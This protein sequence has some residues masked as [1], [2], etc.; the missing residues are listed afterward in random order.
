MNEIKLEK[1]LDSKFN[2]FKEVND[3]IWEYAEP[4]FQETCS[5]NLQKEILR[6]EG[7]T[8]TE[9]LGGIKTAFSAS[10]G[11]G[12]PVIGILGEFD[13]LP[14]LSQQ[15]DVTEKE[16]TD[17][18]GWGHGCGH[19]TLGT[20]CMEACVALKDYLEEEKLE[21]TIIYFGCPGEEGGAGKAFMVREGCFQTCDICLAWHPYSINFGSTSTLANARVIYDFHGISSHA[22]TSPHLGRSALDAVEL[23]NVGSNY[24]REHIL[25]EARIHYAITNSGGDA[26]NVVQADAQVIYAIRA[27][28]N[29]Q[30]IELLE[31]V[32]AVA[33]GA[34]MMTGTTVDIHVASAYADVLQNK[35]L[36]TLVYEKMKKVLPVEYSSEELEYAAKFHKVGDIEDIKTYES[37]AV[38]IL[39]DSAKNMFEGPVVKEVL[40]PSNLKMGSTD[41]GDVSWNIP[42]SWFGVACYSLGTPAH[43]WQA[44]AQGKSPLAHK[45]MRAAATILSMTAL[46]LI[47][48]PTLVEK[49]KKD[50]EIAKEGGSYK[51]I[52][53]SEIK[54]GSF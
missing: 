24:L 37:M 46:E 43:S 39:G 2:I 44:V 35:T 28:G 50:L 22:A 45:G 15:A 29:N 1:I 34:A 31:R 5:S 51:S 3:K 10:F 30:V 9:E 23:M 18:G 47:E 20:A 19:N 54:A 40:P 11:S 26:P 52:I 38:K 16:P 8:I 4:R 13:A 49:A 21:A 48:N 32:N 33:K 41:V 14:N 7:F 17:N 42:T 25:P 27:S 6:K 36:D 12:Y 53:P